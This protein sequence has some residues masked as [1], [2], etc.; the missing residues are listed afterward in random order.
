MNTVTASWEYCWSRDKVI[1]LL[2][3]NLAVYSARATFRLEVSQ[4]C[5]VPWQL[6]EE[7]FLRKLSLWVACL[8]EFL[9]QWKETHWM[10]Q[11]NVTMSKSQQQHYVQPIRTQTLGLQND[12]FKI[13]MLGIVQEQKTR[14]GTHAC[15][16]SSWDLETWES[17]AYLVFLG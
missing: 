17:G 9:Y 11:R 14:T 1:F 13:R 3:W 7:R 12:T 4:S 15:C 8:R 10:T 2:I 5:H 16:V 6:M